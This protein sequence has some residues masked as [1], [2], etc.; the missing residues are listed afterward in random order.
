MKKLFGVL[1]AVVAATALAAPTAQAAT[2]AGQLVKSLTAEVG[3]IARTQTG[4]KRDSAI[5]QILRRR[6]DWG[7]VASAALGAHWNQATEHQRTRLL[8]AIEAN[9]TRAYSQRLGK[10]AGY[11]IKIQKVV[12]R[13]SGTWD[14]DSLIDQPGG[15][16]MKLSWEV[17]DSGTG[18]RIADVKVMGISLSTTKRAE[19]HSYIQRNGGSIEPLVQELEARAQR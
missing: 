4:A 14:V 10:L 16:P 15:F 17:R 1:M 3:A 2:D 8:A 19:F 12:P 5:G 13:A 7:A 11:D 6:F 18:P 9:E